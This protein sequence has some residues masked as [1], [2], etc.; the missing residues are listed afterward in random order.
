MAEKAAAGASNSNEDATD[1]TVAKQNVQDEEN[2]RRH[3]RRKSSVDMRREAM[4]QSQI[5]SPNALRMLGDLDNLDNDDRCEQILP[6]EREKKQ[7]QLW[8]Q[9]QQL[10]C[11]KAFFLNPSYSLRKQMLL[12][13]G[14]VSTITI[15]GI[16]VISIVAAYVAGHQ[17]KQDSMENAEQLF[18]TSLGTT[19]RYVAESISPRLMPVGVANIMKEFLLDRFAGY[20]DVEDDSATPFYSSSANASIYPFTMMDPL[21]PMDW[22]FSH[23]SDEAKGN[24]NET[25]YLEHVQNSKRLSWYSMYPRLSTENSLY[26]MQGSC[27][28]GATASNLTDAASF[29]YFPNCTDANNDISTGGVVAPTSVNAQIARKGASLSPL[30]KSL[31][32]YH[33]DIKVVGYYFSN[34]GAGSLM[35]FPHYEINGRSTYVSIGC[36]WMRELNPTN[37]ELGPIASEEEIAR[38]HPNGSI[39]PSREYNTLE[40]GWCRDQALNPDKFLTVGPYQDAWDPTLWV[41]TAGKAVYDSQTGKF[42][43]CIMID[44]TLDGVQNVMDEVALDEWAVPIVSRWDDGTVVTAPNVEFD[45]APKTVYDHSL[46]TGVNRETFDA[47]RSLVD[48]NGQ[49]DPKEAQTAF[50]LTSF[51]NDD[52]SIIFASPIPP[53]PADYD[54]LYYPQF[55]TILSVSKDDA[56]QQ[57]V[58]DLGD[59]IDMQV[60]NLVVFSSAVGI[61]GI[62]VIFVVIFVAAS[63]LTEPLRWMNSVGSE[64]V[65]NFGS[66]KDADIDFEYKSRCVYGPKT[67]L[68]ALTKQ[69]DTLI[70]RFS[71]LGSAKRADAAQIEILNK[72]ALSEEFSDLYNSR[73]DDNFPFKYNREGVKELEEDMFGRKLR[74]NRGRNIRGS[75]T[76]NTSASTPHSTKDFQTSIWR[77]PLFSSIAAFIILPVIVFSLIISVTVLWKIS[78]FSDLLEPVKEDFISLHNNYLY[79]STALRASLVSS[80]TGVVARDLHVITRYATWL[81]FGALET[82]SVVDMVGTGTEECKNKPVGETCLWLKNQP[83]DCDWGWHFDEVCAKY[84]ERDSRPLQKLYMASQKDDAW[85]D[86]TRNFTTSPF[87]TSPEETNWWQQISDLPDS[88]ADFVAESNYGTS[89]QRASTASALSGVLISFYNVMLGTLPPGLPMVPHFALMFEADGMVIGF[90]GCTPFSAEIPFWVSSEANGAAELQPDLCPLGKHAY[91]PRCRK[92]YDDGKKKAINGESVLH[93]TS[94]YVFAALNRTVMQTATNAMINKRTKEHI[95]QILLDFLPLKLISTLESETRLPKDGFSVL[96]T[97]D[98]NTIVAPGYS[99]EEANVPIKEIVMKYDDCNSENQS[100]YCEEFDAIVEMMSA[101]ES[102][103]TTF[104]RKSSTG[105][106]ES[107]RISFA[108]VFVNS[109]NAIDSSNFASGVEQERN[110][111]YSVALAAP[112]EPI[113]EPFLSVKANIQSDEAICIA[114]ISVL[115]VFAL[116]ILVFV[117][118]RVASSLINPILHLLKVV[119]D[120]NENRLE[121]D[122]LKQMVHYIG[123]SSM[124]VDS[125]YATVETLF[126]IM[127]SANEAFYTGDLVSAHN[128]LK[129][130]LRLFSRLK[131]K[132]AMAVASNNL[133]ILCLTIYRTMV[134]N[135]EE[136][137]E[138]M[139]LTDVV[140]EGSDHFTVAIKL[141]EEQYEQFYED[142]G[143]SEECLQFMQGLANR[144][145]NRAL[146][147]LSTKQHSKR[148]V[149]FESNGLRDIRITADMDLEIVDQCIEMGFRIDRVERHDLMLSRSRGVEALVK[150]GYSPDELFI[151]DLV[152]ELLTSF[153]RALKN[154]GDELFREV[155]PAGRMQLLDCELIKYCRRVKK[156]NVLAAKV[157]IRCLIEDEYVLLST[158]EKALKTILV[159]VKSVGGESIMINGDRDKILR[160]LIRYIGDADEEFEQR[161]SVCSSRLSDSIY[162]DSFLKSIAATERRESEASDADERAKIARRRRSSAISVRE[163]TRR[164]FVVETF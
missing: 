146:L 25:N 81:F 89:F 49:W 41:V 45:A 7:Q 1:A 152:E 40:R 14:A 6:A 123:S 156:D 91:D 16:T 24:V 74:L 153:T 159:Y 13:F 139:T 138:G 127:K 154:P 32:E 103:S 4:H 100:A 51:G 102:G 63:Y 11:W 29:D 101:G 86:G 58:N 30:L 22:D 148:P 39:V 31:F 3:L 12:T 122:H 130:T 96:I 98:S 160:T 65:H 118:Y 26:F 37:P 83:C 93:I 21:L 5:L 15:V 88:S 8:R 71:R 95:G 92:W 126:Q 121:D 108:P 119:R 133:G 35:Q 17:A 38:C 124:E 69:F 155:N 115:L 52:S 140:S 143:W 28:P 161:A 114:V 19:A 120:M 149:D 50:E 72:F 18:K 129:D 105:R 77:S 70:K 68:D 158:M 90:S 10:G 60:H 99:M 79:S 132:K 136:S 61:I 147:L 112:E 82:I 164:D 110:L 33:Q 84:E 55:V 162:S 80:T 66:E 117:A 113:L 142:Q 131:N 87:A 27:N 36:D 48:F 94:P 116:I 134:A 44:I 106:K 56:L 128:I 97:P 47:I 57:V 78:T 43:A 151:E 109:Y 135:K 9:K 75:E 145:F 23:T 62:I 54:P 20:P 67:E 163:A 150:L 46:G 144:Y 59:T 141:G 137:F 157:A 53:I 85:Q 42:I 104:T 2:A 34:E 76:T 125:V 111:I 64:I 73:G 107:I